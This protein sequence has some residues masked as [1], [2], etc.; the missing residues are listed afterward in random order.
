MKFLFFCLFVGVLVMHVN[1]ANFAVTTLNDDG[2]GSLRQAITE[3]NAVAG[4]DT[5]TF[6]STGVIVLETALPEVVD[7]LFLLGPGTNLLTISG[8]NAVQIF[9][10]S[11]GTTN[12]IS[13]LTIADGQAPTNAHGGAISNLSKLTILSCAFTNNKTSGGFGG[14]IYNCSDV[15]ICD[16]GFYCNAAIGGN[17]GDGTGINVGGGGG[18][19]GMGGAI[20]TSGSVAVS[21]C[22]YISNLA[23]GGKGGNRIVSTNF[24][25][26]GIG[27]GP[28]GGIGGTTNS[29]GGA[30]G[31]GSGGGGGTGLPGLGPY[32]PQGVGGVG[33][34]AGGLPRL[35]DVLGINGAQGGGFG[36]AIFVRDASF[37]ADRCQFVGNQT[38][39]DPGSGGA[40]AFMGGASRIDHSIIESNKCS[41]IMMPTTKWPTRSAGAFG[42]AIFVE[43]G[44]VV[45]NNN[46]LVGNSLA[47]GDGFCGSGPGPGGIS[48]GGAIFVGSSAVLCATNST[49]SGNR[50]QGGTACMS[51]GS[52]ASG[53]LAQGG[54]LMIS[55]GFAT[56][57]NCTIVTNRVIGGNGGRIGEGLAGG[58]FN[59]GGTC[60]M[61]NSILS[62]NVA[63][64]NSA[65]GVGTFISAGF[66]V[67]GNTNGIEG[68]IL[69][70]VI[71][72]NIVVGPLQTNLDSRPMHVLIPGSV[73][74]NAGSPL[75]APAFDQRG[76]SR[77]QGAGID[78]GAV[79]M[80]LLSIFVDNACVQ[81]GLIVRA[82]PSKVT[83]LS[84]FASGSVFYTVNGSVPTSN[85]TMYSTPFSPVQ[86]VTIRAVAFNSD[87]SQSA[88]AGPV[89]LNFVPG[90]SLSVTSSGG[91]TVLLDPENGPYASG[92]SV[93][94]T[95]LPNSGKEFRYW[96]GAIG[97]TNARAT[98]MMYSNMTV[99]GVFGNIRSNQTISSFLIGGSIVYGETINVYAEAQP[100]G[101]PATVTLVSGPAL[102]VPSPPPFPNLTFPKFFNL[103][104]IGSVTF[105]AVHDGSDTY[106]PAPEYV[107]TF[108]I[109]RRPL[110]VTTQNRSRYYG[111]P[112]PTF[113]AIVTGL[114][115][116]DVIS[117]SCYT[118][119]DSSSPPGEYPI[120]VTLNGGGEV[121]A[122]YAT[123][124]NLGKLTINP[125]VAPFIT[126]QPQSVNGVELGAAI[127]NVNASGGLLSYQWRFNGANI[128]GATS[129]SLTRSSLSL[130]DAGFYDVIITNVSGSITS[131]VA[132]LTVTLSSDPHYLLSV[133]SSGGGTVHVNPTLGPYLGGT[134]VTLTAVSDPGKEFLYWSGAASGTNTNVGVIMTNNL[135]LHAVFANIRSNQT[136]S[137]INIS[138]ETN[139]GEMVIVTAVAIPS[140]LP[141]SV[142]VVAGPAVITGNLLELNG[143]GLV[144]LRASQAGN[145]EYYPAIDSYM[146][147]GVAPRSLS[148]TANDTN[149]FYGESNPT[150]TG[151]LVGLINDDLISA[152]Y[153]CI[154]TANSAPDYYPI[155]VTLYDPINRLVNYSVTTNFGA[156]AVK[157]LTSP[158]ITQSPQSANAFE[159]T[160]VSFEVGTTGGMLHFQWRCNGTNITGATASSLVLG[161][162]RL[163]DAGSFDVVVT[164]LAG[165]ATSSIATL[166]VLEAPPTIKVGLTNQSLLELQ[167]LYLRVNA[168]SSL[169][170]QYQWT[171][172]GIALAGATK[173]TLIIQKVRTAD[174]GLYRVS[175]SNSVGAVSSAAAVAIHVASS[176]FDRNGFSDF[177]LQN[178][179]GQVALWLRPGTNYLSTLVNRGVGPGVGWKVVDAADFDYDGQT[180]LLFQHTDRQMEIW[181]M[182]RTNVRS[183]KILH[184]GR[185]V[186]LGWRAVGCAD[187]NRNGYPDILFQTTD[188]SM[189]LWYMTNDFVGAFAINSGWSAGDGWS[190]IA[191]NNFKIHKTSDIL[192]R[193]YNGNLKL[194][195]MDHVDVVKQVELPSGPANSAYRIAAVGQFATNLTDIVWQM[196]DRKVA[197]W[198]I[199]E[200]E[201]TG[202]IWCNNHVAVPPGWQIVAPK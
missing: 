67:F 202:F 31:F 176:D 172:N 9:R 62:A 171:R 94:L 89:Q 128:V 40:M 158:I 115:N 163:S 38:I 113:S 47:G 121:L 87:F 156:L 95:A 168:T 155:L 73:A 137:S 48:S 164:N 100:S 90:Y 197:A 30:G 56:I 19:A 142:T 68:V 2:V 139:Y 35:Q 187:F 43:A 109:A 20:F 124:T 46:L 77:P 34:G 41:A 174:A 27:G 111:D 98:V 161:P 150:F 61:L 126:A 17:G 75:G 13:G 22:I 104:N 180:D 140:G 193:H 14:A 106:K 71:S 18:G 185:P 42:G 183:A 145:S 64:T 24:Q 173:S 198:D 130:T 97:G 5:I 4:Q 175:V 70:D 21:N 49:F 32:F 147:L 1:A 37:F 16:S 7:S 160:L 60:R 79:E 93:T 108:S 132:T 144:T 148:V 133:S 92:T 119:A 85:S 50:A 182:N 80:P 170:L 162:L 118:E 184:D 84:T 169:P 151:Q 179:N 135:E 149:R 165:G 195:A 82:G 29:N 125:I 178:T 59:D 143:V 91:G 44:T 57:V 26:G 83:L 159:R 153:S 39:G 103:T 141:V 166:I 78:I 15:I 107:E 188:G 55:T 28:F 129:S 51:S 72:T 152:S 8:R 112:N 81:T 167:T 201:Y 76:V 131:S 110:L 69:S 101:Y 53:G 200:G 11:S 138:G 23:V 127:L 114:T 66:N 134:Y 189:A 181:F 12:T 154:A 58:V 105:R 63:P 194:W 136:I 116:N 123:T 120:S 157:P 36:G 25:V 6:S 86:S 45:I 177:V 199:S 122:K 196:P 96:N 190:A 52:L 186:Q 74:I 191:V 88:E 192:F 117:T 102:A 10:L 33:G 65:D 54:G 99:Q 3:A 146:T